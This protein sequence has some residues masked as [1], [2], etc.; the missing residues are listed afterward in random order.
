MPINLQDD[1]EDCLG[2]MFVSDVIIN[3][4]EIE[5][6]LKVNTIQELNENCNINFLNNITAYSD[7]GVSG[8]IY[9]NQPLLNLKNSSK[10]T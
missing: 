10:F 5:E 9:L 1:A 3:D 7:I 6:L 2:E 8:C 4:L